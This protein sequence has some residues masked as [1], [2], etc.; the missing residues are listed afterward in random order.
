MEAPLVP[1]VLLQHG[2][3]VRALAHSL[4]RDSHAAE[5]VA[6]ETW[7]RYFA[8]PPVEERGL[9]PW[10]R[11]VARNL[12]ANLGRA[13]SRRTLRE[14][15][16]ARAE[17]LPAAESELEQGELLQAV[18][19]AVLTLDEPYRETILARYW[20]GLDAAAVATEMSASAATVRSREQRAR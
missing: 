4:L 5:D 11:T 8:H 3:F 20:R 16:T 6:Q 15:Q 2:Q 17:A 13:E 7:A 9:R 1:E 19:E 12:A 10:L 14:E 18:V